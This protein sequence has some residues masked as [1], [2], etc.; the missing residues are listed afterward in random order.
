MIMIT[1][2]CVE[3]SACDY[4]AQVATDM[5]TKLIKGKRI[6]YKGGKGVP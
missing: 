1:D 2:Y 3:N 6:N 5:I 4:N